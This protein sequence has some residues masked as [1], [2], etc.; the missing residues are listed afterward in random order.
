VVVHDKQ[1]A[2]A[3]VHQPTGSCACAHAVVRHES[4]QGG[5]VQAGEGGDR[6]DLQHPGVRE[7]RR[8]LHHLRGVKVAEVGER[9]RIIGRAA[10]IRYRQRLPVLAEGVEHELNA[11]V[12]CPLERELGAA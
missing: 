7:D 2:H 5:P 6:R 8:C 12:L 3:G 1:L 4:N 11:G 9:A 10:G